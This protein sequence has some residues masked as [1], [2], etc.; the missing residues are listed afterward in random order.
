MTSGQSIEISLGDT[1]P[2]QP[3][4]PAQ[5][6]NEHD[7]SGQ[8]LSRRYKLIRQLGRGGMGAVYLGHHVALERSFAIK[9]LNS[10]Y[11]REK[12]AIQRFIREARATAQLRHENVVDVYDFGISHGRVYLVMEFLDG[13]DLAVTLRRDGPMP[14]HRAARILQQ[15][16]AALQVAHRRRVIHRDIKPSNCFR[17]FGDQRED[18]IKVLDF[19][20]AKVLAGGPE[21]CGAM[22][23]DAQIVVGTP[24]YMAPEGF[25]GGPVDGRIDVYAVGMLG[26]HLLTG[27][28]PFMRTAPDF[29]QKVCAGVTRSPRD[30]APRLAIPPIA[31]GIVMRALRPSAAER[32]QTISELGA[33][34]MAAIEPP[35]I[36]PPPS[37]VTVTLGSTP[38]DDER[39]STQ[40]QSTQLEGAM[41]PWRVMLASS[42]AAAALTVTLTRFSPAASEPEQVS[43]VAVAAA[44]IDGE[45]AEAP[46]E[47][48]ES[49]VDDAS[50]DWS[51]DADEPAMEPV[52]EWPADAPLDDSPA[53]AAPPG[54]AQ[55]RAVARARV[56]SAERAKVP[57]PPP[58]PPSDSTHSMIPMSVP[59]EPLWGPESLTPR[60]SDMLRPG[61]GAEEET[62]P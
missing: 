54:A 13:E 37:P 42:G 44:Q 16:C 25:S 56:R 8:V 34:I 52:S 49:A 17:V 3:E 30:V 48:E 4:S 36:A 38:V 35:P 50:A 14:W 24:E 2:S 46:R 51:D 23:T 28:L 59:A 7:L 9:V 26:Y 43:P 61:E 19:G 31:D 53:T 47:E 41:V 5:A 21:G 18:F 11:S 12:Y 45:A 40:R 6:F 60:R 1:R 10:R 58:P 62:L 33:A 15:V 32:F 20:V 27:R 39:V 29:M 22:E 55:E 57:P